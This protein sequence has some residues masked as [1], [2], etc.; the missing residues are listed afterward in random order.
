MK[1]R[2]KFNNA[3]YFREYDVL[4]DGKSVYKG[5]NLGFAQHLAEQGRGMRVDFHTRHVYYK[6]HKS[7]RINSA[8]NLGI[9]IGV[10]ISLTGQLVKRSFREFFSILSLFK[11]QS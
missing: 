1:K 3:E 11:R 10:G 2:S 4:V 9:R 7:P 5:N 6:H 8:V